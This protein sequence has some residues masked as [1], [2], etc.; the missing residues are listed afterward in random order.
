MVGVRAK[1]NSCTVLTVSMGKIAS[2]ECALEKWILCNSEQFFLSI[3]KE[4]RV[5]SQ[6]F[7]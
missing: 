5:V 3:S 1:K 4:S 7:R 2:L 6:I